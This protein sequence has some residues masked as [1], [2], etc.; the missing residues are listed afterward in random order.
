MDG[1]L[2]DVLPGQEAVVLTSPSGERIIMQNE[3]R[4]TFHVPHG[5][6]LQVG[7]L[8]LRQETKIKKL[9]KFGDEMKE[10]DSTQ[11]VLQ[12]ENIPA[13]YKEADDCLPA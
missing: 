1:D 5:W 8:P 9:V 2:C 6:R 7:S 13:L 12:L 11:S 4:A 10:I 3:G